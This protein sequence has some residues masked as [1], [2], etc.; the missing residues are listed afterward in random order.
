MMSEIR[1]GISGWRSAPWR[2]DFYPAGL[3]DRLQTTP[4][5]RQGAQSQ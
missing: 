3:V 1:I 4:A 5:E 2:G